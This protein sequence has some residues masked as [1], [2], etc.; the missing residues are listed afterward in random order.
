M[1]TPT[2]RAA[3]P[4]GHRTSRRLLR[5]SRRRLGL[6]AGAASAASLLAV[7]AAAG[8]ASGYTTNCPGPERLVGGTSWHTH[9]LAGGVVLVEGS[10]TDGRG[11][12][13]MHVLSVDLTDRHVAVHPL[14]HKLAARSPLS[15]LAAGRTGLIAATNTG[16]FDFRLGAP[17]G[18]VVNDRKPLLAARTPTTVVGLS[19]AGV[20]QAGQL[21]FAGTVTAAGQTHR[22]AGLNLATP[23]DGVTAYDAAWGSAPVRLPSDA[24]GRYVKSGVIATVASRFTAAPTSGYLLVARGQS[25]QSWLDTLPRG[26]KVTVSRTVMTNASHPFAQAYGVGSQIVLP[27]GK[28]RTDLTC[29]RSYPQPARTAI[30]FANHGK[31]LILTVVE[32]H[33]GTRVHGLDSV[34]MSRLMADLGADQAFL[35]D[36]SGST[37]MLARLRSDPTRLQLRNYPA[38]GQERDM[39]MGLGIFH[40]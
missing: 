19:T 34:Q 12:V 11:Q 21:A 27:G 31:R 26:T 22:L 8:T 1:S 2:S 39:P 17:L 6:L 24:V 18:P 32:D 30:G 7:P 35:L 20:M 33:P 38:D 9:K 37:E 40:R 23:I 15:K 16:Y 14:M 28:T 5:Q 36:G 3:T 4:L 10:H 29:R 25:A 13:R